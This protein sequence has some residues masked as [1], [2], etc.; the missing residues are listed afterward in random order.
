MSYCSAPPAGDLWQFRQLV[1]ID[2]HIVV[3]VHEPPGDSATSQV[4]LPTETP[5]VAEQARAPGDGRADEAM[6]ERVAEAYAAAGLEPI[7]TGSAASPCLT[8]LEQASMVGS[9]GCLPSPSC[10]WKTLR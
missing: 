6:L 5:R 4:C 10:C 7:P 1:I 8:Y 2:D 9:R 3:Q